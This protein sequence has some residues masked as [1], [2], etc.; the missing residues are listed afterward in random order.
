MVY[1]SFTNGV[2]VEYQSLLISC[3]IVLNRCF[4]LGRLLHALR[5]AD[6]RRAS[7]CWNVEK[8]SA[9]AVE[10]VIDGADHVEV[11]TQMRRSLDA[12]EQLFGFRILTVANDMI[13]LIVV[14]GDYWQLFDVNILTIHGC[15]GCCVM[16]CLY[17]TKLGDK[18]LCTN[19]C[20]NTNLPQVG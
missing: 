8:R 15:K 18:T 12:S 9:G 5:V 4:S 6:T 10:L 13:I 20:L 2:S 14:K 11:R 16:L 3:I 19:K 7:V 1:T 17:P